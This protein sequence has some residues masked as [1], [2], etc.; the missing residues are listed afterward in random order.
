MS[1]RDQI[2]EF[3]AKGGTIQKIP[4][5]TQEEILAEIKKTYFERKY[6][7]PLLSWESEISEGEGIWW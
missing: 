3:F 6:D 5:K 7:K 4:T 2:D 1:I